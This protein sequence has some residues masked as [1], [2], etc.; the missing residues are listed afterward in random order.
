VFA[1]QGRFLREAVKIIGQGTNFT[2]TG[3]SGGR[4]TFTFC[5]TCGVTVH[6]VIERREEEIVIPVGDFSESTFPRPTFS[7]YEER[8][9][10]WVVMPSDIEHMA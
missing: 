8:M 2:R 10:P 9:H 5:S 1:A 6:Y 3:D 7:V 4:A